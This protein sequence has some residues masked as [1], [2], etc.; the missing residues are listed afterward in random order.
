MSSAKV[1]TIADNKIVG[2]SAYF[3]RRNNVVGYS[4]TIA[5]E[6]MSSAKGWTIADDIILSA[7][8]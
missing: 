5:D 3:S 2:Y 8:V 7:I 4:M 6:I 1:W